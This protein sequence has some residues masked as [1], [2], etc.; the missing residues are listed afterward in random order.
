MNSPNN[1]TRYRTGSY[2]KLARK[3]NALHTLLRC[4][5]D[6]PGWESRLNKPLRLLI[7]SHCCHNCRNQFYRCT[8]PSSLG[9]VWEGDEIPVA[10]PCRHPPH[11]S[12]PPPVT[13][14]PH[15]RLWHPL[16]RRHHHPRRPRRAPCCQTSPPPHATASPAAAPAPVAPSPPTLV[17]APSPSPLARASPSSPAPAHGGCWSGRGG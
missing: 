11:P 12:S 2:M 3:P 7:L 9:L 10:V 16:S 1:P 8:L 6:I 13:A 4:V 17:L 14:T 15:D 5:A